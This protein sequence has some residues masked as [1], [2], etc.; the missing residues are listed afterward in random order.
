[1][2]RLKNGS[3]KLFTLNATKASTQFDNKLLTLEMKSSW[4]ALELKVVA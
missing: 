1:M 3:I 2:G 4:L